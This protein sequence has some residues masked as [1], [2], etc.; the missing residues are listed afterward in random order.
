MFVG[1]GGPVVPFPLAPNARPDI[2]VAMNR[3]PLPPAV[4]AAA[5]LCVG[6]SLGWAASVA[7][8]RDES[9]SAALPSASVQVGASVA[10]A[11]V[12]ALAVQALVRSLRR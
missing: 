11:V 10:G 12:T 3:S 2:L 5:S 9:R 7:V 6:A 8:L 1:A 4:P